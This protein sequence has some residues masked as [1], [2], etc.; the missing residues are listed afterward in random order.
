MLFEP[1]IIKAEFLF[2]WY[3]LLI[4]V[5]YLGLFFLGSIHIYRRRKELT[6]EDVSHIFRSNALPTISFIIPMYNESA[7]ISKTI[8]SILNL[9][10]RYKQI[11]AVNDG[12]EDDTLAV[13]QKEFDLV[14]IPHFYEAK[15]PTQKVRGVYRSRK[16]PELIVIDKEHGQKG[17]TINAGVN[18]CH[19][20]YFIA[21]DADTVIDDFGFE[22]LVRPLLA[23]PKRVAI[24]AG[25]RIQNGCEFTFNKIITTL[26]P[27]SYLAAFQNFEYLR[28][29]LMRQGW[30]YVGGNFVVAGAFSVFRTDLFI[31]IGGMLC[32]PAEDME[33]IVRLQRW[34]IDRKMDS[35]VLYLPDPVAWTQG[36]K[37]LKS[38][39]KQR[40]RWHLGLL[41]TLWYHKRVCYNVRY[42]LF[43]A[44]TYPFFLWGEALEP[45][46][47]AI[48]YL[49]IIASVI[50]QL[51]EPAFF[52][53]LLLVSAGFTAF[54]SI[55]CILVEELS[56][57]KYVTVHSIIMITVL[58]LIEN[59]GY[60]QLTIYW[61]LKSFVQ[62]VKNFSNVRKLTK[63]ANARLHANSNPDR[64]ATFDTNAPLN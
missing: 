7:H 63:I 19:S 55:L 49:T 41:E 4:D 30:N 6:A 25:V 3:F 8:Y 42:R 29:F 26:F 59:L 62:F 36:P 52:W 10:Y 23:D 14:Q 43:G 12:S 37:T 31:E 32:C 64:S 13:V 21:V 40:A 33:I 48:G 24:G 11:L 18:A 17:D 54:F 1:R 58:S 39:G 5:I 22:S 35:R 34:I 53:L 44:F 47:E 27:K 28:S 46:I 50:L 61:R 9:N 38:L 15:I 2:L 57:R 51:A 45:V 56:Y 60:R 16:V 20:S